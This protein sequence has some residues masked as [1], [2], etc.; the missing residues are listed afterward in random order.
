M[1]VTSGI[2]KTQL[3]RD[4]QGALAALAKQQA[5]ISSGRRLNAPAD[6]PGGAAR[7]LTVRS[8][9]AAT[10]Q[11]Q[12]NIEIVR[13]S[14]SSADATLRSVVDGLQ[15]A[16]DVAIQGASDSNDALSRQAIG[17]QVDQILEAMVSYA[18][19]RAPGGTMLFG[20]QEVATAPYTVTRDVNGAITAVTVN[21]RGIAGQMLAEV[22]DGLTVA[23]SVPG[24]TVFG[25]MTDPTNVFDTLIRLRNALNTNDAAT[26]RT[27]LDTLTTVH[28]RA[29][30]ASVL[31]GTRLGWLDTLENRLNDEAVTF[32]TSLSAIEDVDMVKAV[33]DLVQIQT[34]YEAGLASGARLLRESL[35]DFLR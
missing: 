2:I 4:L 21:A 27:E 20:G 34:F 23:Q 14:L 19:T 26:V 6:D 13:T 17:G 22:A 5:M 16:K 11:L 33:S 25:A 3:T 31:V 10:E 30:S 28:D 35:V 18:N 29:T 1:R 9:Q 24:T 15:Q 7:A 12:K 8:R 32:A